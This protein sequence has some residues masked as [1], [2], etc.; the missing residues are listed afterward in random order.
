M[1]WGNIDLLS[2]S[3]FM[4]LSRR[5]QT[6][7]WTSFIIRLVLFVCLF[8]NLFFMFFYFFYF[9]YFFI[10]FFCGV[11]FFVVV[12]LCVF[13]WEGFI[14]VIIIIYYYYYFVWGVGGFPT[15]PVHCDLLLL[16]HRIGMCFPI[17]KEE[18]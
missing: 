2:S 17:C 4:C 15:Q 1:G 10:Y 12:F 7:P 11:G 14:F 8:F 18:I 6:L 5:F 9:F 13:R 16:I 3:R